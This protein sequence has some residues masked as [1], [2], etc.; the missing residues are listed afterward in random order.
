M[1]FQANEAWNI[2][3]YKVSKISELLFNAIICF[4]LLRVGKE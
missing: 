2:A 4:I 1:S 3:K